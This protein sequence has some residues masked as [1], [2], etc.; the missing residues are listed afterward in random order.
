MDS[1]AF[2]V[3]PDVA[4][5]RAMQAWADSARATPDLILL[6]DLFGRLGMPIPREAA[7]RRLDRGMNG[8]RV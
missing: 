7:K 5:K 1:R 4:E 6:H 2:L 3:T 8:L